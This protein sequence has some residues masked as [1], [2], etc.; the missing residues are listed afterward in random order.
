MDTQVD[1]PKFAEKTVS[2]KQPLV[3]NNTGRAVLDLELVYLSGY[4]GEVKGAGGIANGQQGRINIDSE[5]TIQTG[6]IEASDSFVADQDVYYEPGTSEVAGK[7]RATKADGRIPV[8]VCTEFGGAATEHTSV[9]FRPFVQG[10]QGGLDRVVK[11]R[12]VLI[13]TGSHA[14]GTPVVDTGFPAGA[15]IIKTE[16]VGLATVENAAV[17]VKNGGDTVS[18]AGIATENAVSNGT[19][20]RSKRFVVAA[21]LTFTAASTADTGV[22]TVHYI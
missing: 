11:A 13:P 10:A 2:D 8:G 14:A 22:I 4:F 9:T 6:Q 1:F 17:T 12:Q 18:V 15:E 16:G 3:L 19:L 5:R 20:V 21:G 7:I